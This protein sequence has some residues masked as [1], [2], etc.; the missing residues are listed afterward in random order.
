M[1]LVISLPAP[2]FHA[3]ERLAKQRRVPRSQVFAEALEEYLSRHGGDAVT[4]KLD[5]VYGA[6]SSS[7]DR[8]LAQ[9]QLTVIGDETW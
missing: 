1:K 8:D 5:D 3:A 7:I 6:Q 4:V 9:A 2:L